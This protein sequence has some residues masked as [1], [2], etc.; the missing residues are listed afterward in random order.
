MKFILEIELRKGQGSYV[1]SVLKQV[2]A[3]FAG[4]RVSPESRTLRD[5]D[6]NIIGKWEVKDD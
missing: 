4:R 6:C 1:A 3:Y 2:A 5:E